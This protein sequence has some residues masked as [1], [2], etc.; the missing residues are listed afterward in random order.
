MA[1]SNKDK[2]SVSSQP[3][4]PSIVTIMGSDLA[5]ITNTNYL[6]F[7][8][9]QE[10][11]ARSDGGLSSDLTEDPEDPAEDP[12]DPE[13]P[14]VPEEPTDRPKL[15]DVQ[16]L[17]NEAVRDPVTNTLSAKVIFKVMNSSGKK[18]KA[19]NVRVERK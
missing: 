18:L 17:T 1:K 9:P 15:S 19:I 14:E 11:A 10:A 5:R 2:S 16:V 7:I 4:S 3:T 6:S 8:N 13:D 12:E